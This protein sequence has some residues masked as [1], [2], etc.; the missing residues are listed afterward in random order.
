MREEVT[1]GID[2]RMAVLVGVFAI[3]IGMM[4]FALKIFGRRGASKEERKQRQ[5]QIQK[6][7]AER[8]VN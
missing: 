2:W 6:L 3:P 5:A 1:S 7:R 8:R 4:L